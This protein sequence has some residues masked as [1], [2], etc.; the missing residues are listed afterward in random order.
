MRAFCELR[1]AQ[2]RSLDYLLFILTRAPL[3]AGKAQAQRG[4]TARP[5]SPSRGG[6][7]GIPAWVSLAPQTCLRP[8]APPH[9]LLPRQEGVRPVRPPDGSQAEISD[10]CPLFRLL[11]AWAPLPM[12]FP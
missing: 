12:A 11:E 8:L 9:G 5:G 4:G 1:L 2:A 6:L 7:S 10:A 3:T